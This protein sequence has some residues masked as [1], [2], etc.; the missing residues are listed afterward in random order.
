MAT[1]V[2]RSGKG[3]PLTHAEVDANF[4]NLNSDKAEISSLGTA[5]AA[6]TTDFVAQTSTTGAAVIPTGTEAQRPTPATGQLRFNT[7][8]GTFEGY[9]GTQWGAI[10]GGGGETSFLQYEYTATAAQTTFSGADDNSA[11]LSYTVANLIVTLNGVVLDNGGD[12]T[13]TNGTSVVLTSGAAAGDLLQVIAFK[14]FTVADMVPASTGGT[15]AG[16]VAVT[17]DLTIADKIIHADDTNTAIRFPA[18][19]TVTVETDGTE[20][21]RVDSS[22]NVGIGVTAP[23]GDGTALHV[24]G[25]SFATLHLTNSTTGAA[26]G[27][28]FDIVMD[29]SEALLRNRE[30]AAMKFATA[31]TERA[32]IDA[33]GYL[34]ANTTGL[35]GTPGVITANGV[36]GVAYS[37]RSHAEDTGNNGQIGFTNPNGLVGL[38]STDGSSTIYATSS[39]YRLKEDVQPMVGASDRL[40]AL[41]PVNFA[42]KVDGSRVDGFLAHEAQQVVPECVT[43]SKDEVRSSRSKTRM[44]TSLALRSS[45]SIRASTKARSSRF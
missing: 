45:P 13:A 14:S 37:F 36:I 35:S 17:G 22:G 28:G 41:K 12:Y 19:D 15:F 39:D 23:T 25:S 2:T 31:G 32:R 20:R 3:S 11:T 7:D 24:N 30:S 18:A 29:G 34:L 10:A 4:E 16:N 26:A 6:N 38:I 21:V 43:G 9:D 5:A 27:D 33:S 1:I 44:A 8:A 42:W 40:M